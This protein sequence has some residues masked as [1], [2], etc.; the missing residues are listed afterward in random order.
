MRG[1]YVVPAVLVPA[2]TSLGYMLAAGGRPVEGFVSMLLAPAV[3][4]ASLVEGGGRQAGAAAAVLGAGAAVL[5]GLVSPFAVPLALAAGLLLGSGRPGYSV[6]GLAAGLSLV[7]L[8]GYSVVWGAGA[9][10]LATAALYIVVT[11]YVEAAAILGGLYVVCLILGYPEGMVVGVLVYTLYV[12]VLVSRRA[13]G[14]GFDRGLVVSG[15]VLHVFTP[16]A[17]APWMP[18]DLAWLLAAVSSYL[19]STGLLSPRS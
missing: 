4:V 12:L 1:G 2:G 14:G 17:A 8:H 13:G 15:L 19:V 11:G 5:A 6:Y 7:I 18:G 9:F 3:V 10:A 16:F